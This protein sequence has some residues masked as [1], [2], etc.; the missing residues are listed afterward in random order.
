MKFTKF[1][2]EYSILFIDKFKKIL[3]NKNKNEITFEKKIFKYF[4]N[5]LIRSEIYINNYILKNLYHSIK[6]IENINDIKYPNIYNNSVFTENLINNINNNTKYEILYKCNLLNKTYLFYFYT[7]KDYIKLNKYNQY[8]KQMLIWLYLLNIIYNNQCSLNLT[9]YLYFTDLKKQLPSLNNIILDKNNANSGYTISCAKTS[10]IIIYRK[11]EWLKV[12]FH[13]TLHNFSLDFSFM[14]LTNFNN[15]IKTIF[16]LNIN[17]NIYES[18]CETWARIINII[19]CSYYSLNVDINNIQ[20]N[21]NNILK[22]IFDKFYNHIDIFIQIERLFSLYQCN[23]I[24]TYMN[25]NFDDLYK[26]N[27]KSNNYNENTNIFSYYILTAL[28]FN[29]YISFIKWCHNNN[30]NNII[31]FNENNHNL[32]NYFLF[33]KKNYK[34]KKLLKNLYHIKYILNKNQN[35]FINLQKYLRMSLFELQP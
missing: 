1:S 10:E 24:L 23:K 25:L 35:D 13:E 27:I 19:F 30:N 3:L 29:D 31:K 18:Y 2:K 32:D 7:Q 20:N 5:L 12:F 17:F 4:F 34:N 21:E 11:E 6:K 26:N 9:T 33:I 15:K 16:P 14:D 28:F 22:S 8:V